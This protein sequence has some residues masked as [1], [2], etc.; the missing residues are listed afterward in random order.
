M[1]VEDMSALTAKLVNVVSGPS[2]AICPPCLRQLRVEE[3]WCD[4]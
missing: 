1:L 4:D 2:P 3:R